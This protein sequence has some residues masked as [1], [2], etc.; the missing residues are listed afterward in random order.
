MAAFST[1]ADAVQ[2]ALDMREA[3]DQLNRTA[4]SVISS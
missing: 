4:R 2:A 3:V 1:S